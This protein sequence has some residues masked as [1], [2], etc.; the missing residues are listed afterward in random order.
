MTGVPDA[1][2]SPHSARWYNH[3]K[4]YTSEFDSLAGSSTAGEAFTA[5][6][7]VKEA[8][9]AAAEED[10][11][12]VDL[13]GSDDEVDE[14]AERVKAERVAAYNA[15][16]AG[17]PK[18]AAKV[19]ILYL[20]EILLLWRRHYVQLCTYIELCVF[21]RTQFCNVFDNKTPWNKRLYF[22]MFSL[23]SPSR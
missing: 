5:A 10:D 1:K 23:S 17:K 20:L 9:P 12:E 11:D 4:S 14:E 15:K 13:F 18:A 7:A 19:R 16:K 21:L 3:I 2:T 8:A 6:P 22:S